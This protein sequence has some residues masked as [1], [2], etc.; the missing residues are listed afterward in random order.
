MHESSLRLPRGCLRVPFTA[1]L[2]YDEVMGPRRP[3]K[4][5]R[6]DELFFESDVS[7]TGSYLKI[8]LT[9][10]KPL[11]SKEWPLVQ[12]GVRGILEAT[13]SLEKASFLSDGSLLIKTRNETQTGKFLHTKTFA[14]E[15]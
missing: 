2:W 11:K 3:R 7:T 9:S 5:V 12:F 8:K 14:A 13:D 4:R 6:S 15:E 1:H 10:G